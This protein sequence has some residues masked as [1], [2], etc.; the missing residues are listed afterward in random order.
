MYKVQKKVYALVNITFLQMFGESFFSKIF[1][2]L[3]NDKMLAWSKLKAFA[4]DKI[5]GTGKPNLSFGWVENLAGKG[6]MLITSIF[7]FSYDVFK[8]LLT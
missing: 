1:N 2:S 8:R 5:N 6:K 7:S 4:D 3:S